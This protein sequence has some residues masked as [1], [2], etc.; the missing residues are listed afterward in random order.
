MKK[1]LSILALFCFVIAFACACAED[2]GNV[3]SNITE[4]ESVYSQNKTSSIMETSSKKEDVSSK[5]ENSSKKEEST[6]S[7]LSSQQEKQEE[8]EEQ[9]DISSETE[10][11]QPIRSVK[12]ADALGVGMYHFSLSWTYN[13]SD[14]KDPNA[15]ASMEDRLEELR[16]VIEA[17]Y[18]NTIICPASY[19]NNDEMWD[20]L[21]KNK[22]S[23]WLSMYNFYDSSKQSYGEWAEAYETELDKLKKNK[24]RWELFCGFHHEE[25]IWRGQ[26]NADFLE[27]TESLYRR[28]GKRNMPVFAT[29]EFT[30]YEG[31][32]NQ[33]DMDAKI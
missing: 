28:Y 20:I 11:K 27:M 3:S 4:N 14:E 25:N 10:S 6:S 23:V 24:E 9:E 2:K 22:V 19:L 33:I 30:G 16:D 15:D 21:I 18:V 31:N 26:S 1:I 29:G 5:N 17:G 8:Q 12:P 7:I 32:Q 13:Y